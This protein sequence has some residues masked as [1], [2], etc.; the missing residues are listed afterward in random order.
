MSGVNSFVNEPLVLAVP[1]LGDFGEWLQL[2]LLLVVVVGA[3]KWASLLLTL[4]AMDSPAQFKLAVTDT[5]VF[6]SNFVSRLAARN[7]D[8]FTITIIMVGT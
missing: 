7:I 6:R 3:M 2:L 1:L 5:D 8:T 4:V